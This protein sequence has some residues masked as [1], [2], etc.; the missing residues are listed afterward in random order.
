MYLLHTRGDTGGNGLLVEL[1]T[2]SFNDSKRGPTDSIET[3]E[4]PVLAVTM[5]E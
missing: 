3:P 2:T 4:I 5:T 1:C